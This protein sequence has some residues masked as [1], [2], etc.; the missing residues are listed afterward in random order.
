MWLI[1]NSNRASEQDPEIPINDFLLNFGQVKEDGAEE[2]KI[3]KIKATM[4]MM[5]KKEKNK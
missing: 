3:E 1:A 4:M 5:A 2:Q